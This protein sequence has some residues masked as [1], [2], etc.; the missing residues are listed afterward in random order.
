VVAGELP[1]QALR[2]AVANE[3]H[4]DQIAVRRL[5]RSVNVNGLTSRQTGQ[6]GL[7]LREIQDDVR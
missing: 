5:S 3:L 1:H 4:P 7:I 2:R 6:A